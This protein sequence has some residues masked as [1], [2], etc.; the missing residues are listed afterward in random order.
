MKHTILAILAILGCLACSAALWFVI[1][2]LVV[3]AMRIVLY[4]DAWL[5][6]MATLCATV[7]CIPLLCAV[8]ASFIALG[9]DDNE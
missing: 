3:V 9:G 7:A 2:F 4:D 6:Q 5:Y 8:C 1:K